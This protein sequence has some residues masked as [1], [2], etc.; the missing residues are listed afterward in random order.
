MKKKRK[1]RKRKKKGKLKDKKELG[2]MAYIFKLSLGDRGRWN[3][4]SSKPAC[5]TYRV[6]GYPE[7]F[8]RGNLLY[9]Q[10]KIPR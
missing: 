3:S 6:P 1:E 9:K 5:S 2:M 7:L 8:N 4:V 10:R